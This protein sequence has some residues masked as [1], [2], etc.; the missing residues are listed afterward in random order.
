MPVPQTGGFS[1]TKKTSGSS[2]RRFQS[3]YQCLLIYCKIKI[4]RY[5]P[6]YP[7][8]D[9]RSSARVSETQ[10]LLQ[11][12]Q[13]KQPLRGTRKLP[14]IF[15]PFGLQGSRWLTLRC[16]QRRTAAAGSSAGLAP[17]PANGGRRRRQEADGRRT[18]VCACSGAKGV[19]RGTQ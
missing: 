19:I 18:E 16:R 15:V 17:A 3:M 1:K 6:S 11:T 8:H 13:R 2:H 14:F 9:F 12:P 7:H 10:R 5:K 4:Q